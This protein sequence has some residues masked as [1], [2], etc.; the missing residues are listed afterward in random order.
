MSI[1]LP[2]AIVRHGLSAC[3]YL[4]IRYWTCGELRAAVAEIPRSR[5]MPCPEC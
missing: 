5:F 4:F 1:D 2:N 3:V